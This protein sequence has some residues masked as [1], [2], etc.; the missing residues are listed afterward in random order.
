M[1]IL[2]MKG[3]FT[4][5]D[6]FKKAKVNKIPVLES[7]VDAKLDSMNKFGLIGKTSLY[8]YSI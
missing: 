7:L 1:T 3:K 8:Y 4:I 6:V 2:K 5:N